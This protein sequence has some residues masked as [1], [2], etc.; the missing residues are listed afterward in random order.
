MTETGTMGN[1]GN[2]GKNSEADLEEMLRSAETRARDAEAM[3]YQAAEYGKTLLEQ[4]MELEAA[5]EAAMQEKHE[6]VLKLQA[7]VGVEAAL[8]GELE[9]M[10]EAVRV[11]EEEERLNEER[12]T[13]KWEKKEETWRARIAEVEAALASCEVKEQGLKER[14]EVAEAQLEEA[15][16]LNVSISGD[17]SLTGEVAELQAANVELLTERQALQLEVTRLKTEVEDAK[18]EARKEAAKAE[19]LAREVEEVQV[20]VV[21][22]TRQVEA[23]R[24]EVVELEALLEAERQGK[25]DRSGK[26]NSLFSEVEDRREKVE[27]QLKVF[28]EKFSLLKENY[29][30]KLRELQKTKLHNAQLLGLVGGR[31][32]G[33]EHSARLEELLEVE[34]ER[35]RL[36]S[37]RLDSLENCGVVG[38]AVVEEQVP[39][40]VAGN[41][42][43]GGQHT[44]SPEFSYM[45]GMV[46][47]LKSKNSE[48]QGQMQA[49]LRQN[50]QDSDK[51]RE[52]AM[53][54]KTTETSLKQ[55]RAENYALKMKLDQEKSKRGDQKVEKKESKLIVE[56][57][58]FEKEEKKEEMIKKEEHPFVLKE[59][60]SGKQPSL[61]IE[62][63]TPPPPID[64]VAIEN[65]ENSPSISKVV[66]T[67]DEKP[68]KSAMFADIV[69]VHDTETGV[70]EKNNLKE[71]P[72]EKAKV[73]ARPQ[74]RKQGGKAVLAKEAPE[75]KQ[76]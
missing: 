24:E 42:E 56:M 2:M 74:G 25:L 45:A 50:L 31:G 61:D 19:V 54:V 64:D 20:E 43:E 40:V 65:K 70:V 36:L 76:Q 6:L 60:V 37:E 72:L 13:E 39:I 57:L 47:E 1:T 46:K 48:L 4:N 10:R 63:V 59:V 32:G 27:V 66:N 68:K 53:K 49:Q 14:L 26:G 30:G 18:A 21:G 41:K 33:E 5:K 11:K 55:A 15:A 44:T 16:Q 7:K 35:N 8:V 22:Y 17:R 71:E 12:E 52:M 3:M 34:R 29:D 67:S 38:Q 51:M 62:R 73:R 69:E 9:A 28:E 75:C 58:K 23:A